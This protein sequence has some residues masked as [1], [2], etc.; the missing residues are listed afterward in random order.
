MRHVEVLVAR[1]DFEADPGGAVAIEEQPPVAQH[2]VHEVGGSAVQGDDLNRRVQ[3]ALE[4]AFQNELRGR[5]RCRRISREED[6]NVDIAVRSTVSAGH[7]TEE[8]DR[9]RTSSVGL[10]EGT[11]AGFDGAGVHA[12]L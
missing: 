3:D 8:V 6:S 5:E 12:P 10:E 7:A 9:D 1:L 4:L 11:E 2:P